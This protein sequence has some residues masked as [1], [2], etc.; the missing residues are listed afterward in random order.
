MRNITANRPFFNYQINK[1]KMFKIYYLICVDFIVKSKSVDSNSWKFATLMYISAFFSIC[2]ISIT[3]IFES[4]LNFTINYS[5]NHLVAKIEAIFI[6]FIPSIIINYYF[7]F[8]NNKHEKLLTKYNSNNGIYIFRFLL[9][10]I[11][12]FITSIIIMLVC[13][14]PR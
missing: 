4:L 9:F 11:G 7:I 2:I 3:S 13:K 12:I 5:S 10:T 14:I 6:Y 8:F 1:N